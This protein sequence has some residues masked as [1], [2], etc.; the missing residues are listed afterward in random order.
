MFVKPAAARHSLT[1]LA[2]GIV[3]RIPARRNIALMLFLLVWVAVWSTGG[4]AMMSQTLNGKGSPEGVSFSLVWLVF[5]AAGESFAILVLLWQLR[6][7][8]IITLTPRMLEIRR[9][10]FGIG[11]SRRYDLTQVRFLRV[12]PQP[13]NPYDFRGAFTFWGLGGGVLAFDY[14]FRT[15]RFGGGIDEAEARMIAQTLMDRSPT[16]AEH[17]RAS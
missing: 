17:N 2:D 12:A 8:E 3:I 4:S 1:T 7:R 5:W 11:S 15:Y 10:I 16:L 9:D 6:G 13:F 14:G